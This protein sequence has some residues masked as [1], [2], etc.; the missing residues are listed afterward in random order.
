LEQSKS[1]ED[2]NCIFFAA[3][4]GQAE[5]T[6]QRVAEFMSQS[7]ESVSNYKLDHPFPLVRVK[8]RG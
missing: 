2:I 4:H 7:E 1:G 6:H 3:E 8:G 5:V